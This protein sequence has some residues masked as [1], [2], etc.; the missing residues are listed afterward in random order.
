MKLRRITP[1]LWFKGNAAEAARFYCRI[2]KKSKLVSKNSMGCSFEL[3][4]QAFHALNAGTHFDFNPSISFFIS[5]RDQ[6]EVDYYWS[7]LVRG[8]K[9]SRCGWLTDKYGVSWQVVP[10]ALGKTIHGKNAAGARRAIEAMMH[11]EKLDVAKLK[12]AYLGV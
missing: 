8:G 2:F 12:A 1:F 11:M 7:R 3:D 4:G 9:P 6:K 5:C 10:Q